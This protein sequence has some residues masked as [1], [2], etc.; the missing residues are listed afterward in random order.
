M[1]NLVNQPE[2]IAVARLA[3]FFSDRKDWYRSLWG[4]GTTLSM[5]ELFESCSV[6]R[7][8]HLSEPAVKRI[9]SSLQRRV[10]GHP[11]FSREEKAF[12]REQVQQVPRAD[13]VAHYAIRELSERV[14]RDYLTRWAAAVQRG[15]FRAEHFARHVGAHLLDSGFSGQYLRALITSTQESPEAVTL[16]EFCEQLH[17]EVRTAVPRQFEV[18]LAFRTAPR[19]HRGLPDIWLTGAAITGWLSANGFDTSGVRAA[20]AMIITVR[21]RDDIGAAEAARNEAERYSARALLGTGQP[22]AYLPN[23]WVRGSA[24]VAPLTA[25][26]RGVAVRELFRE[27]RVFATD[28]SQDVDAALELLAHL[29][30]S[31]PPAAVAGGWGAIEGLLADPS[32]R[33]SAADNLATLVTC[34]FPRAELTALSHRVERVM[35]A[36]FAELAGVDV[37]RE[38]CRILAAMILENRIPVLPNVADQA[39]VARI[40]KLLT[41]PRLELQ[42]IKDMI[43]DSFHRLYRQRNMILHG[44]RL[45]SVALTASLRTVAKLAGAGMDRITHGH[46]VQRLRPLELVAKANMALALVGRDDPL[47]CVDLLEVD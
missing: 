22:L 5:D 1:F 19:V 11:A 16:A 21:A 18:M 29:E 17:G 45:D 41:D 9:A 26:A 31:S 33:S 6:M 37:N 27:D 40:R 13:G 14:S 38:R 4:I 30:G 24:D 8:G 2:R 7:Q 20:A 42:T 32:D 46:Y 35:P 25:S 28:V 47:G 3:E 23:L 34:S 15:D 12:L 10:G 44:G 43:G 36:E 39:A